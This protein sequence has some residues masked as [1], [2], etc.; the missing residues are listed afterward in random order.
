MA[1][2]AL[3]LEV[4]LA[5]LRVADDDARRLDARFVVARGA[6]AVHERGNVRDLIV[7]QRKFRHPRTSAADHGRDQL[8]MLIVEHRAGAQ[9]AR[10]AVAAARVSAVAELAIDAVKRLAA[11]N[12][13]RVGRRPD[14]VVTALRVDAQRRNRDHQERKGRK[15]RLQR[16]LAGKAY[17]T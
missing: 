3:V 8:A 4:R 14:R 5:C 13:G 11:F 2:R 16:H 10:A 17:A 1:G 6:E 12:R 7:G 15:A 9:Q